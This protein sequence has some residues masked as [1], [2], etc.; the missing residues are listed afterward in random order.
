MQRISFLEFAN[1]ARAL[2]FFYGA[3]CRGNSVPAS[4]ADAQ[5]TV[6]TLA[7]EVA[8]QRFE[9]WKRGNGSGAETAFSRLR[10][11]VEGAHHASAIMGSPSADPNS[12]GDGI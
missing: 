12:G 5:K 9:G 7:S 1:P 10:A 2:E 4:C 3:N 8:S 11:C 6:A